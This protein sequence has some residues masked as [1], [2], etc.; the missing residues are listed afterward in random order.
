MNYSL[1][2]DQ[3]K[4]VQT[5]SLRACY[6]ERYNSPLLQNLLSD[7]DKA[8]LESKN[9]LLKSDVKTTLAKTSLDGK[10]FVIKRYNIKDSLH[11]IRQAIRPARARNCWDFS[12][13]ISNLGISTTPPV[14]WIQEY[15]AGFRSR[16]WFISEYIENGI[17]GDYVRNPDDED[18]IEQMLQAITEIFI[19]MRK[20]FLS[21]G[22]MKPPNILITPA[23]TVLLDLDAM[24]HHKNHKSL[25]KALRTDLKRWM[26]WWSI[27]QPNPSIKKRS[28]ELL[29]KAGF[30]L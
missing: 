13:F 26:Q 14:A 22:D 7:P 4:T 12:K 21:H 6:F 28:E 2:S 29:K 17:R 24:K 3:I 11:Q 23:S 30:E 15:Q 5:H 16:S 20:H 9:N 10:N 8:F 27:D 18:Y 19:I 1:L 25:N